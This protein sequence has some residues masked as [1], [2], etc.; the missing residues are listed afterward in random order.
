M[1]HFEIL[2]RSIRVSPI[3]RNPKQNVILYSDNCSSHST[4]QAKRTYARIWKV[5]ER[6]LTANATHV[7]QPIDQHIGKYLQEKMQDYYWKFGERLLDDVDNGLR[8]KGKKVGSK[9]LRALTC[10]WADQ[11]F[12][13]S[14]NHPNLFK[15]SWINFGLYLPLSGEKDNDIETIVK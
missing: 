4:E 9:E 10:Q 15:H 14:K 13:Q 3:G 1:K 12:T 6:P 8:P 5:H 11:A 2:T 7:Q